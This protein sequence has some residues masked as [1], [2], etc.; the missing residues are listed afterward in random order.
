MVC[1]ISRMVFNIEKYMVHVHI[2]VCEVYCSQ[3]KMEEMNKTMSLQI[4]K[5]TC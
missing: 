4:K 5:K 3:K 1:T 2:A